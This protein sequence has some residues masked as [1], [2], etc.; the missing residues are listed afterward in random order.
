[1]KTRPVERFIPLAMLAILLTAV[2]PTLGADPPSIA[3]R[4]IRCLRFSPDSAKLAAVTGEPDS[5]GQLIVWNVME[6]TIAWSQ[7]KPAGLAAIN[8]SPNGAWLAVGGFAPD[9]RILSADDGHELRSLVGHKGPVRCV[10]FSRDNERLATGGYDKS[11]KVWNVGDGAL[12]KTLEGHTDRVFSVEFSPDGNRLF[13]GAF[14]NT[15]RIWSV[16]EGRTIQ[17]LDGDFVAPS[18][19]LSQD[20]RYFVVARWD[21]KVRIYDLDANRL[22]ARIPCG[23][24]IDCAELSPDKRWLATCDG[25]KEAQLRKLELRPPTTDEQARIEGLVRQWSATEFSDRE[26]AS[27]DLVSLGMP[28]ESTLFGLETTGNAEQRIRARNA[29]NA[30]WMA[31]PIILDGYRGDVEALSFSPDGRLLATG[32]RSGEIRLWKVES[33]KLV[34]TLEIPK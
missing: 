1:M 19:S 29:R 30:I 23:G 16:P 25:S 15:A 34:A 5:E 13:S 11:L 17:K 33:S 3:R 31:K 8:Y 26:R 12:L 24:G 10:A 28:A 9:A 27:A 22:V 2:R 14:D 6:R 18:V 4:A 21:G 32:D 20:G 7:T